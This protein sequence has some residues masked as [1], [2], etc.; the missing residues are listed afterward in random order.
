KQAVSRGI[1]IIEE[2]KATG[3]PLTVLDLACGSLPVSIAAMLEQCGPQQF[4]Y[5]GVDL[6][7]DQVEI[8]RSQF[9]FSDN[10][11]SARFMQGDAW[12]LDYLSGNQQ[13]YIIF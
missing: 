4:E 9:T 1:E 13:F 8:A 2:L 7:C 5:T 12:N 6:N 3:R 10:G 11:T